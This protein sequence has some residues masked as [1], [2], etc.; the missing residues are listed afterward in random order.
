MSVRNWLV[1]NHEKIQYI[2]PDGIS[3][4]LHDPA[5]KS[6]IQMEGWGMPAAEIAETRGP[7]QHGSDP[8]TIR[9][10]KREIVMSIR[11]NGCNRNEYWGNREGLIDALRLNRTSLNNPSPGKLRWY[12]AD[13]K[14][15]QADVLILQGPKFNPS[16]SGWDEYNYT[17]ELRFLA[18]N[19]ILYDPRQVTESFDDLGCTIIE[20]LVMPFSFGGGSVV[21]GGTT[22]NATNILSVNYMGNWQEYPT[23][24]LYGP[25]DNFSITHGQT[26]LKIELEDYSVLAGDKVTFDLLYGRKFV[27]LF[28]T[29][30]NL[31]GYISE[32][33]S[34]GS[35][36]I[37]P[38]PVVAGGINDFTVSIDNGTGDTL[39]IFK[40]YNR[41]IAI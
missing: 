13:G 27:T 1:S 41:F 35:F 33:S 18:H 16:T 37:E 39:V 19:P 11:H 38:D 12:R 17:D 25:A 2:S 5:K 36:A 8:L 10:P 14:I 15:R 34:L 6:I 22:C 24:E 7:F 20:E 4:N 28:S 29:G 40:Y 9:M 31:L 23:I 32:D 26:G 3:Y 30:E 21:F